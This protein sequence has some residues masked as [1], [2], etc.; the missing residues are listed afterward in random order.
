MEPT[1]KALFVVMDGLGDRGAE[2]PLSTA[3]SPHLDELASKST[4]GLILTIGGGLVPGSDTAHLAL[5][6]YDPHE[7]YRGRGAFEALGAGMDLEHGDVAFRTNLCTLDDDGIIIDRRAGREPLGFKELYGALNGM[8]VEDCRV[9]VQHTVEHRGAM[10]M[11]G[12][13]LS[14]KIGNTDPH[15][16]GKP[17]MESA[18][19]D[20]E[21]EKAA[22]I[23]NGFT[24][25]A[26]EILKDH[27]A[28][29]RRKE[30][31][32]PPANGIASRG[33]G[34]FAKV[35]PISERL[36]LR[37]ACVAGGAL[38]KGVA[39]YV[40]MTIE[41]AEGATGTASTNLR[42]KAAKAL[43]VKDQYDLVFCHIKATD[44]FGHD[45]DFE[46]KRGM[47][48]RVDAEFLPQVIGEF[49]V[50]VV[51]G[52]HTT[53]CSAKRHTADPVPILVW[54]K[55]VRPDGV[56]KLCEN[57]VRAG[58][59]GHIHGR[60]VMRIIQDYLDVSEMFGE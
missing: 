42:S 16:T 56:R 59:L 49:D 36:N 53:A 45:G 28:N 21:G 55:D 23:L 35:K 19:L 58:G 40:G 13:G 46:G 25:K 31:D 27:P 60:N 24:K 34:V 1:G 32:L 4:T 15:E 20:P 26:C 48:E 51:T 8:E 38:Y 47:I 37:A 7:Y 43:E 50:L 39:R 29:Q 54:H 44:S 2:T 30:A 17:L 3:N 41:D 57:Q 33:P 10:V 12:P 22:R 6:G 14:E 11:S 9:L 5:F 18:P 52:D